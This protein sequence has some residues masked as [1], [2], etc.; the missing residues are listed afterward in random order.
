MSLRDSKNHEKRGSGNTL[1]SRRKLSF[2]ASEA[3]PGIQS[4]SERDSKHSGFRPSPEWRSKRLLQ[5]PQGKT[6]R[7]REHG[8]HRVVTN[9]PKTNWEKDKKGWNWRVHKR[10]H[11]GGNQ[12]PKNLLLFEN[13][14]FLRLPRIRSGVR[15]NDGKP[16]FQTF[17]K[18]IDFESKSSGIE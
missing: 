13:I 14:G 11:S 18:A 9:I 2:R 8:G 15:Q 3:R 6:F 1:E 5:E 4:R 17:C 7:S 10:S 16:H 12:R